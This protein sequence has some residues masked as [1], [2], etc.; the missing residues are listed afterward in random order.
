VAL[1]VV[2]HRDCWRRGPAAAV[3]LPLSP[4]PSAG[5]AA[6]RAHRGDSELEAGAGCDCGHVERAVGHRRRNCRLRVGSVAFRP[7]RRSCF[8][9]R[10]ELTGLCT[11]T[12]S[13]TESLRLL[14]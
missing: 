14:H 10:R 4:G 9:G 1:A 12:G 3:V 6:G 11:L 5:L 2:M 7:L 13:G 8:R